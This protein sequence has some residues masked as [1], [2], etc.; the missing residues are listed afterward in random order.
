MTQ[1]SLGVVVCQ[2][3]LRMIERHPEGVEV[4]EQLAR[5]R[6]RLLMGGL[7]LFETQAPSGVEL[8]GMLL[9]QIRGR[10]SL[11]RGVDAVH[12]GLEAPIHGLAK[13]A[14]WAIQALL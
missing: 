6:P 14:G 9:A 11:T 2:R 10:R 7:D 5:E 12:D 3:Q 8:F 13:G 4:V 1:G